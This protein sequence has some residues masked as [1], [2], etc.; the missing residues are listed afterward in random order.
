MGRQ[1][2]K[3]P[4]FIVLNA[5]PHH[6]P[7]EP[8]SEKAKGK[9][10]AEWV[11]VDSDDEEGRSSG[12]D[13]ARVEEELPEENTGSGVPE[14]AARPKKYGPPVKN[15]AGPSSWAG[16]SKKGREVNVNAD[17]C[18]NERPSADQ[19]HLKKRKPEGDSAETPPA[20]FLKLNQE[21]KSGRGPA[22]VQLQATVETV[23]VSNPN[24]AS[25]EGPRLTDLG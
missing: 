6:Q 24:Q 19:A 7:A 16:P 2:R 14:E 11:D 12:E 21:R 17:E 4:A 23:P 25:K 8:K 1:R 13:E 9:R 3:L 18:R 20:K 5:G 10:K 22:K 15:V